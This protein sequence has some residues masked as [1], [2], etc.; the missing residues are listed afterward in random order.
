LIG[1]KT[2]RIIRVGQVPS[3]QNMMPVVGVLSGALVWGLI[4]YTYGVFR[5]GRKV[6][7]NVDS[8][9]LGWQFG[10]FK[11]DTFGRKKTH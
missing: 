5:E 1:G 3:K 4:W 8:I 10:K 11:Y 7:K 2:L 6:N 9:G